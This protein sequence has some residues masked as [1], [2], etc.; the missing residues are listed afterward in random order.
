M[1][2][3]NTLLD[4]GSEQLEYR[5]AGNPEASGPVLVFLHEG[6]GCVALWKNFPDR[7]AAMTGNRV[8]VFSRSCYGASS[9]ARYPRTV[10]FMHT[11]G[12]EILPKVLDAAGIDEAILV[13]HSDGGSISLINAGGVKDPR[14][15]ALVLEAAH[16]FVEDLSI[17]GIEA[18]KVNYETGKLR[19]GLTR[20]HGENVE[21]AFWGWNNTWLNPEFRDW[22]I[23]EFLP[24]VSVPTLVIQGEDDAYGTLK[25][26]ES[27]VAQVSG[28]VEKFV[29]PACGHSP[30]SEKPEETLSAM[31]GF[32][33]G[34]EL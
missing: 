15:K 34:L 18:A 20:Y 22:N 1:D 21:E 3:V 9:V 13:G 6:L 8:F 24:G 28:P 4:V 7:L 31:A 10:Q 19:E 14:I 30:H 5:W 25:Q 32:I 27:I 26:V 33:N 11:E 29:I 17:H 12:L 23:E 16:V 2:A